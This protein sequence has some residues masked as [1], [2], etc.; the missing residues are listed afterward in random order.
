MD[1]K[2][3][4]GFALRAATAQLAGLPGVIKTTLGVGGRS[5]AVELPEAPPDSRLTRRAFELAESVYCG[6][7]QQHCLRCWYFGTAFAQMAGHRFDPELL[8]VATLLHDIALT[9]PYRP[10]PE[11]SPCF[12]AHGGTVARAQLLTWGAAAEFADLVEEAIDLH[13]DVR[14]DPAQGVEAHLLHAAAHLDVAGSRIGDLPR[15]LLADIVRIHPRD[16]FTDSFLVAMRREAH[17]RPDSRAAVMWKLGMRVPVQ[18]NPLN[19][20]LSS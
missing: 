17:E 4:I 20:S 18:L 13:M 19:K 8:Y 3:K 1:R 15:A 16:R 14:V 2:Q 10:T 11:Q 7:L 6:E 5:T 12:A 9:D